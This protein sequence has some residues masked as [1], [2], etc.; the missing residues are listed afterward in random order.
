MVKPGETKEILDGE[1]TLEASKDGL[2][3]F[4]EGNGFTA[5]SSVW[6]RDDVEQ[7]LMQ[8]IEWRVETAP[9]VE[10]TA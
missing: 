10:A 9:K 3:L 7:L 5:E 4:L 1:V 6:T 8:L 2:I